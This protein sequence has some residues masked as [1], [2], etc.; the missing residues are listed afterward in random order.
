MFS[1]LKR[2][3]GN[4]T[5]EVK[6]GVVYVEGVPADIIAKEIKRIWSTS[7]IQKNMFNEIDENSFSFN[8]FFCIEIVYAL[9]KIIESGAGSRRTL[10]KI[11]Q[12]IIDNSWL[13][14]V[15]RNDELYIDRVDQS[16]LSKFHFSP[17]P[18]QQGFL[19]IYGSATSKYNLQGMMLGA[20][21]GSG[22]TI[23]SLMLMEC[24]GKDKVIIVSPNNALYRVWETTLKS[25]FKKP[26]NF[27]I[28][29]DAEVFTGKEK[30]IVV[31]YE[32][33]G[34]LLDQLG[35]IKYENIGVILDESHNFNTSDTLRVNTFIE[36]CSKLNN[37]D[38]LWMSG[39]PIKALATET[40][41]LFR[42]IDSKFTQ[43]TEQRF[44]KIFG[45]SSEHGADIIKNRLGLVSFRVEK[46]ELNLDKPIFKEIR[47]KIP[48]AEEYTLAT[49]SRKMTEFTIERKKYY[50]A[51]KSQD[52]KTFDMCLDIHKRTLSTNTDKQQFKQYLDN[53]A[54]V[55]ETGGDAR[56]AKEEVYFCNK[57][58]AGKIIPSLPNELRPVFRD[59]KSIIKY[60]MMKIQGECLGRVV[61][62][63]RI[64]AHVAICS[65]IDYESVLEASVKKTL[66]F[67]SFVQVIEKLQTHLPNIGLD[68]SFVYAKT[69][70]NLSN[71]LA[72]FDNS[73]DKNPLV[74]TYASLS[75]AVPLLSCD[76]I[77][78][79][80]SPY[81]DHILQQA[82][83]RVNRIG[84]T[85]QTY[86]YTV[87][88]DTDSRPN[89]STRSFDIMKW[90][91]T[92]IESITGIV[93]PFVLSDNMERADMAL[94]SFM[95][96]IAE[97][98]PSTG[99]ANW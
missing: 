13:S 49:I 41:P 73:E 88:L 72:E 37:E 36:L 32:Y 83:S 80:D 22:K 40:I 81:R 19:D 51:R 86:V 15:D 60:V 78:M 17:L 70:S 89:I 84:A 45:V 24:L 61:G 47:V 57:Y 55:I 4:V 62:K 98:Q 43:D 59:V 35:K 90:S 94:E 21:A 31:N 34:K 6:K 52:K 97:V 33:L 63:A 14:Q 96:N 29:K 76:Q 2:L 42:T 77:V 39:T 11:K 67:T 44:K 85:T 87:V 3:V 23:L 12:S 10:T 50:E 38:V 93:S 46:S 25:A 95:D 7:R 27:W 75:T 64:D 91:Q 71:I 92:Q 1:K 20:A 48:N 69:N 82:I 5:V 65:F 30:F 74:A 79:I 99:F 18:H 26:V 16:K 53:L 8:E 58:E 66:V 68:G 9:D 56:Q 28:S 54:W